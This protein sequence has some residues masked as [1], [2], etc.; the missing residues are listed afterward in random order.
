[1][2]RAASAAAAATEGPA[3]AMCCCC[4]RGRGK[5]PDGA[6]PHAAARCLLQLQQQLTAV[7]HSERGME[8]QQRLQAGGPRG[9]SCRCL[10][11]MGQRRQCCGQGL[12]AGGPD[13]KSSF[14]ACVSWSTSFAP[15]IM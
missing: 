8:G 15:D 5:R 7:K 13:H 6:R 4:C 10:L 3:A 1:M 9:W 2:W 12:G 14:S 11:T